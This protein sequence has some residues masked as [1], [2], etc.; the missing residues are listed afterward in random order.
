MYA[1]LCALPFSFFTG[2]SPAQCYLP[3]LV[4]VS[5]SA[6]TFWPCSPSMQ[7]RRDAN[8]LNQILEGHLEH[9]LTIHN[10]YGMGRLPAL[11]HD[12]SLCFSKAG[13]ILGSLDCQEARFRTTPPL[14]PKKVR[15]TNVSWFVCGIV[16]ICVTLP[17][18]LI[19][20]KAKTLS[21]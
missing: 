2:C 1:G 8:C 18:S 19:E 7:H 3:L 20:R 5:L 17:L 6:S 10:V 9:F 21:L 4:S 15:I 13:L 12:A 16:H 11:A 14:Q